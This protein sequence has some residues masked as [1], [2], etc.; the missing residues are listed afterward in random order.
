M[1]KNNTVVDKMTDL[2]VNL[3]NPS[4]LV[5]QTFEIA[6]CFG[7]AE[8][9]AIFIKGEKGNL[10]LR[11]SKNIDQ[12][13]IE[14]VNTLFRTLYFEMSSSGETIYCPT[15]D[16]DIRFRS[17]SE[18]VGTSIKSFVCIPIV[19]QS[20]TVGL[21]YMDSLSESNIYSSTDL[22][23]LE[24]FSK[25]ITKILLDE[26]GINKYFSVQPLQEESKKSEEFA[27]LIQDFLIEKSIEEI[28]KEKIVLL[29]RKTN[30]NLSRVAKL[31]GVQRRTI[32]IKLKK[33]NIP[34]RPG[35]SELGLLHSL[36]D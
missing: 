5:E 10:E 36:V 6:M 23:R 32:Y 24:K 18:S 22:D 35:D 19:Q 12:S 33:Y 27:R 11:A 34:R 25:F 30:W 3:I 1:K 31:M 20:R 17:L 7:S 16:L 21:I 2:M 28:E 15:L 26:S 29:L 9:G 13:L 4:R 8:R 14:V